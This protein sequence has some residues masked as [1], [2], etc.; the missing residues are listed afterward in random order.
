[1]S[2]QTLDQTFPPETV[3]T[4]PTKSALRSEGAKSAW[5]DPVKRAKIVEGMRVSAE[6]RKVSSKVTG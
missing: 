3:E 1:M 4:V 6:R 5:A 2:D